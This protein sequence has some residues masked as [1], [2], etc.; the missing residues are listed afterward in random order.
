MLT[1]QEIAAVRK[2]TRFEGDVAWGTKKDKGPDMCLAEFR[3]VK[4]VLNAQGYMEPVKG[5]AGVACQATRDLAAAFDLKAGQCTGDTILGG[6]VKCTMDCPTDYMRYM[7]AL[8][9][10]GERIFERWEREQA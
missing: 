2:A 5:E 1:A 4:F 8:R 3:G 9:H 6:R 7:H 10:E